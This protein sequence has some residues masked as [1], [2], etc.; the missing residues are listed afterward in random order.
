MRNTITE[1]LIVGGAVG[2]LALAIHRWTDASSPGTR[3]LVLL[4]AALGLG[5]LQL[6]LLLFR[7]RRRGAAP[8]GEPDQPPSWPQNGR[9]N[10]FARE[11]T[12]DWTGLEESPAEPAARPARS[13]APSTPSEVANPTP[14]PPPL[15]GEGE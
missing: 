10:P 2:L 7:S 12:S 8:P 3:L 14:S 5:L 11:L 6:G 1:S 13:P 9:R 4:L 15:K